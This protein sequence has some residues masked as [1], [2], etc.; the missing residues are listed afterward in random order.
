MKPTPPGAALFLDRDGTI[1]VDTNY[2]SRVED[3]RLL[4]GVAEA[5]R[6]VNDAKLPVIVVT[7]QSGI[8]RGYFDLP[9][10]EAVRARLEALLRDEGARIDD[11]F[12]CPHHPEL[13]GACECR[14]PGTLLYRQ[15][16]Q[17]HNLDLARS[18]FIGDKWRDV[19]PALSLGGHGILVPGSETSD[20]DL[21]L[22]RT[23]ARVAATLGEA[24]DMM[25]L[26]RAD[27]L[28]APDRTG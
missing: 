16:A 2:V 25:S 4:P 20:E 23:R 1:M 15:A 17:K 9:A 26:A 6:R 10:Y 19:E 7:N 14:K 11:T 13:S 12:M 27:T 22:A 8:A 24:V 21:R 28:H 5:V 18:W 3:V